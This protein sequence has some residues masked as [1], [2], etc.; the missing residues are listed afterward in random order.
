MQGCRCRHVGVLGCR[1]SGGQKCRGV[2][3]G[4]KGCK[5]AGEVCTRAR[6]KDRRGVRLQKCKMWE[7]RAYGAYVC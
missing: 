1:G 6:V 4:Q 7:A 3:V 2:D 5:S